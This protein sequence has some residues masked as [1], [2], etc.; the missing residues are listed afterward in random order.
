MGA[1]IEVFEGARALQVPRSRFAPVKSNNDLLVVRSDA[2]VLNPTYTMTVNPERKAAGLPLV[3]L[4][5]AHYG[6]IKEF[7]RRMKVVPSLVHAES[8][9]VQGDVT[10]GHR[11]EVVGK[12]VV[13]TADGK[14]KEIAADLARVE[15]RE[16]LL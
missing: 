13:K 10:F 12:V 14:P 3:S 6:L 11:V 8:L 7:E 4:D 15:S 5:T 9:T 1:A 16:I 2:Y